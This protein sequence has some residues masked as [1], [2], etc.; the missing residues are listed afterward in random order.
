MSTIDLGEDY[1]PVV[2]VGVVRGPDRWWQTLSYRVGVPVC[3]MLLFLTAST[4]A[5]AAPLSQVANI[6]VGDG[7]SLLV[8]GTDVFVLQIAGRSNQL[9]A[10]SLKNGHPE[11]TAPV[12]ESAS[13]ASMRYA[14]GAVLVSVIAEDSTGIHTEAFD[15]ATGNRVWTS[16]NSVLTVTGDGDAVMQSGVAFPMPGVLT[17]PFAPVG[18][19]VQRVQPLTGRVLWT[20]G[21]EVDC[22]PQPI[23][24]PA[25]GMPDGIVELCGSSPELRVL[26]L[27]TGTIRA[28]RHVSTTGEV[29]A[30]PQPDLYTRM[31]PQVF[32]LDDVVVMAH[33]S[34]DVATI[35]GYVAASLDP[36][37]TGAALQS[38]QRFTEC[39]PVICLLSDYGDVVLDPKTGQPIPEDSP[40]TVVA[41]RTSLVMA[42]VDQS[43]QPGS[44][45][46]LDKVADDIGVV[47]PTPVSGNAWIERL[48]PGLHAQLML[49]QKMNGIGAGGC[50]Q[51][52]DYLAC[53]TA[54]DAVTFWRLPK[55]VASLTS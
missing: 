45:D 13:N 55:S 31:E 20:A 36:V 23:H 34:H 27:A 35:D 24:D 2:A 42:P 7:A 25:H 28:E 9:R 12:R 52:G 5:P 32:V 47:V 44:Y 33:A 10:F 51:M 19:A 15:A 26:D 48:G 46:R 22:D 8:H 6:K 18:W 4:P 3:A 1:G 29:P 40:A 11:W 37:W 17:G 50:M 16:D 21:I 41:A 39:D 43:V 49:I 38:W 53:A 54:L 14:G 30:F